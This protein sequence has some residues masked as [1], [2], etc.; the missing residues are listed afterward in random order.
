MT[1]TTNFDDS[2][3]SKGFVHPTRPYSLNELRDRRRQN[4]RAL[5]IGSC[6][7]CHDCGHFYKTR[8]NGRRFHQLK[9]SNGRDKGNCSV[10]WKLNQTPT[11][12]HNSATEL[13]KLFYEYFDKDNA[14]LSY[15]SVEIE[16]DFYMWLY[17]ENYGSPETEESPSVPQRTRGRPSGHRTRRTG[18]PTRETRRPQKPR[19]QRRNGIREPTPTHEIS[20]ANEQTSVL[21]GFG[22]FDDDQRVTAPIEDVDGDFL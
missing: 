10:C 2:V 12:L 17:E 18:A 19:R 6:V 1:S 16:R 4:Y 21:A 5:R 9:N 13:V 15:N 20:Y 8:M 22:E 14:E 11:A 3:L 7:V